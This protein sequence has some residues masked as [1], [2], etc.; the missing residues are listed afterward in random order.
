MEECHDNEQYFFDQQTVDAV[1]DL[2]EP[3]DRP[4]VLCAPMVGAELENRGTE[5]ATLDIDD[6]FRSLRGFRRWDLSRPERLDQRFGVVFCDPP[7]FN[8]S[9]GRLFNALRVLAQYDF[10]QPVAVSY[11]ARRR[12]AVLSTFAPFGLQPVAFD[13]SYRSVKRCEKND[14]ELFT[15]FRIGMH[16]T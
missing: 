1:A 14:V 6:R 16:H 12:K 7:F 3:F 2:L 9:L 15:N 13:L 4:C 11:L 8:V 10:V 5:V